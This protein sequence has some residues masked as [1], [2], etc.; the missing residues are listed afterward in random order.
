MGRGLRPPGCPRSV[1]PGKG[2]VSS[3]GRGA[4][5]PYP[6][7]CAATATTC[8]CGTTPVAAGREEASKA[9]LLGGVMALEERRLAYVAITRA[10]DAP[11]CSG[12]WWS[13]TAKRLLSPLSDFFVEVTVGVCRWGAGVVEPPAPQPGGDRHQ[14]TARRR[15]HPG[16]PVAACAGGAGGHPLGGCRRTRAARRGRRL[17]R[18]RGARSGGRAQRSR[19]STTKHLWLAARRRAAAARAVRRTLARA[20]GFSS[21]G[22]PPVGE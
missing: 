9:A 4:R 22:P 7:S 19:L 11:R 6:V 5:R 8:R 21:P 16:H 18:V 15:P 12:F 14:P 2:R 17:G 1:F 3:P 10:R 13:A 20:H